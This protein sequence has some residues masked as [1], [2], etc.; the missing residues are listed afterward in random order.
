MNIVIV[1]ATSAI[2][3]ATARIW[4]SRGDGLYLAARRESLLSACAQDLRLR[5]ARIASFERFDVTDHASHEGMLRRAR[6]ALGSVDC[7][8]IAHGTLPDQAAC[9]ADPELAVH[10]MT[11][12]G[13]STAALIIRV[14]ANLEAQRSGVIAV[15]T[16]VAAVRG[17]ATNYV[18]GS[19]KALVST[20]L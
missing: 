12:N 11:L 13:L 6:E 19:A 3:E 20:L 17:R 2:A 14:A 5:G 15:I 4:A 8:F 16:S 10:E 18:Y 7:V 1:G 9:D